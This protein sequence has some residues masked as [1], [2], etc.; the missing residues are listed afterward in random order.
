M[1]Y[2]LDPGFFNL[3]NPQSQ[4]EIGIPDFNAKYGVFLGGEGG[5]ELDLSSLFSDDFGGV[6]GSSYTQG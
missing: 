6:Q 2:E 1:D 5:G 3:L 4:L